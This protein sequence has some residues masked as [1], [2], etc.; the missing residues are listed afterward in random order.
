[1]KPY[2]YLFVV[3]ERHSGASEAN[4]WKW[5]NGV[6]RR[7]KIPLIFSGGEL[8]LGGELRLLASWSVRRRKREALC[9]GLYV[10]SEKMS[11]MR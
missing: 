1:M 4:R 11:N 2:H 6:V 9:V 7:L 3:L 10:L 5:V 8:L